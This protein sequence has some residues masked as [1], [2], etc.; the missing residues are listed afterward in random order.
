M[1]SYKDTP[2]KIIAPERGSLFL[3]PD[4]QVLFQSV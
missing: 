3:L 2:L 4:L 1:L